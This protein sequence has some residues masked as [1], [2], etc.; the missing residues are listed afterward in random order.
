MLNPPCWNWKPPIWIIWASICMVTQPADRH[1]WVNIGYELVLRNLLRHVHSA[2]IVMLYISHD[3]SMVLVYMLTWL[4]YIDGINV[5]IYSSTMDPS[6]VWDFV[7]I[8]DSAWSIHG[9]R[10]MGSGWSRRGCPP[11]PPAKHRVKVGQLDRL[12]SK[13]YSE[14]R[15]RRWG[16]VVNPEKLWL[17]PP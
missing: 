4:G 14:V 1:R 3:G 15:I 10:L 6:W 11:G 5:T 9:L 13:L 16:F 12:W 7:G 8:E 17:Y 2:A